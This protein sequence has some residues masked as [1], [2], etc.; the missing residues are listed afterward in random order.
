MR[1]EITRFGQH[2]FGMVGFLIGFV[3][4][5]AFPTEGQ[6]CCFFCADLLAPSLFSLHRGN[7]VLEAG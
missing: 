3:L 6:A 7:L 2:V 5:A 4:V 1:T